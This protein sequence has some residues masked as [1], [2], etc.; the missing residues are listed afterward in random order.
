MNG[1]GRDR[2]PM[3][4]RTVLLIPA[5]LGLLGLAQ[6]SAPSAAD[7]ARAIEIHKQAV[8]R[9]REGARAA[10]RGDTAAFATAL[11]DAASRIDALIGAAPWLPAPEREA[12]QHAARGLE[13]RADG[14]PEGFSPDA[15]LAALDRVGY[16]L[17][18]GTDVKL[19]F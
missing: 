1:T 14:A 5:S 3:P 16:R 4:G 12:L 13:T 2:R 11:K 19:V 9:L 15:D 10:A 18:G 7:R 17:R 8:D 6:V